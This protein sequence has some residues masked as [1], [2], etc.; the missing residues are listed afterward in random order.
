MAP[1]TVY[2]RPPFLPP[3]CQK[4]PMTGFLLQF[5]YI[6]THLSVDDNLYFCCAAL[7]IVHSVDVEFLCSVIVALM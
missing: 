6:W 1:L 4:R 5:L 3:I 7:C 2:Q